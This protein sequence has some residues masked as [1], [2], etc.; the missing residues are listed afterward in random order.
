MP[1]FAQELAIPNVP[2]IAENKAL[3]NVMFMIDDSGSMDWEVMTQP[4]YAVCNYYNPKNYSS[5]SS[6]LMEN[7]L[8]SYSEPNAAFKRFYNRTIYYLYDLNNKYSSYRAIQFPELIND[9]WRIYDSQFNTIYYNPEADYA[10]WA[11]PCSSKIDSNNLELCADADFTEVHAH[12]KEG[13]PDH[14]T[15]VDLDDHE[16]NNKQHIHSYVVSLDDTG[17]SGDKPTPTNMISQANGRVDY[18]DSH[19]VVS[20][21]S[22]N[23]VSAKLYKVDPVTKESKLQASHSFQSQNNC[24]DVLGSPVYVREM[25]LGQRSL[26]ANGGIEC[27][28]IAQARQNYANWF[29][30]YRR[31]AFTTNASVSFIV[32]LYPD[33]YYG[34]H[35]INKL[36]IKTEVPKESDDIDEHNLSLLNDY[37]NN[38]Q[39]RYGTPLVSA[40]DKVGKYYK[41]DLTST[42]PIKYECQLNNTIV[43]TDGY[44]NGSRPFL[45]DVDGDGFGGSGST[46]ADV[47]RY[48]Y[49]NDLDTNMDNLVPTSKLDENNKQHMNTFGVSFGVFGNL[50]DGGNGWPTPGLTYNSNWGDPTSCSDCPEKI[51]DLWHAA[52]NGHGQFSSATNMDDLVATL[53]D[54]LRQ[55]Q[56]Q[57]KSSLSGVTTPSGTLTSDTLVYQARFGSDPWYGEFNAYPINSD[58]TIESDSPAFEAGELLKQRSPES[59]VVF[60]YNGKDGVRFF[61]DNSGVGSSTISVNQGKVFGRY[62]KEINNRIRGFNRI[63]EKDIVAYIRGETK[64]E[65]RNIGF[66]RSRTSVLGDIIHSSPHY[67]GKPF[68]AYADESYLTFKEKYKGRNPMVAVGANDGMLHIFHAQTGEELMAYVPGN[69]GYWTNLPYLSDPEYSHAYYV[70]GEIASNDVYIDSLNDWRTILVGGL[71]AGGQGIYALNVTKGQFSESDADALNSVLFEFSDEDD[72]DMGYVFGTP[73]I[74]KMQNDQWAIVVGNGYNATKKEYPSGE[75][76]DD[77]SKSKQATL[78][79][80]FID[81]GLDGTWTPGTD[82]IKIPVGDKSSNGLSEPFPVDVD[83]DYK[84]DYIYAGDLEGN[85]HRFDVR[86]TK[87]SDWTSSNATKVL[88]A[89]SKEHPI[90]TPLVVGP[91]P[92]GVSKGVYVYFGTGKYIELEDNSSLNQPTQTVMGIIDTLSPSQG[93]V[94]GT[95]TLLKQSIL[96]SY[97]DLRA[98]S[99]NNLDLLQQNGWYMNLEVNGQNYG[100]RIIGRPKL[101][102]QRLIFATII[103]NGTDA[104]M[105]DQNVGI[106]WLMEVDARDGSR[107]GMPPYDINRDGLFTEADYAYYYDPTTGEKKYVPHSGVKS[108]VG[109]IGQTPSI[110]TDMQN[111]KEYKFLSGSEGLSTKTESI[112]ERFRGRQSW[113]QVQ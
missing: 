59:R 47:S 62:V 8:F 109:I 18:W 6:A 60:T 26:T 72:E 71:R 84:V 79:V 56:K 95:T 48:Y 24:Y 13:H 83:G 110:I 28:T 108:D 12:P 101:R 111:E 107:L 78:F 35:F 58:G 41:G 21:E 91:H 93:T 55:I 54:A 63:D 74:V 30:Y 98:T 86:S 19:M 7:G 50:N 100:E 53:R 81:K 112:D 51:D 34:M 27:R 45:G 61:I 11:G 49:L 106:S 70:D 89:G 105:C 80:M 66:L 76:D 23:K 113:Q 90:T 14:G 4:H 64:N 36:S 3:P 65:S 67:I 10:P 77:Y 57:N 33:F 20:F 102:N 25:I 44:Y 37:F 69:M 104:N 1:A 31:R 2:L 39:K 40:L 46:L 82:Y 88:Y 9:D 22:S 38:V 5:C 32:D 87:P 73:Q 16:F 68:L 97:E 42:K 92:Q 94:Y 85:V 17:Y 99:D 52:Y 75:D 96:A 103:P 15:K 29:E 43:M